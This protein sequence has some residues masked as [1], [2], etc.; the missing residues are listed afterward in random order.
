MNSKPTNSDPIVFPD[1]AST[2]G[3]NQAQPDPF[4]APEVAKILEN[5]QVGKFHRPGGHG[6]AAEDANHLAD[7]LRGKAAEIVGTNNSPKGPDLACDVIQI[8]TKYH[9]TPAATIGDAFDSG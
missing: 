3:Q 1:I 5:T 2:V 9:H 8:Q 6:F 4:L 7:W